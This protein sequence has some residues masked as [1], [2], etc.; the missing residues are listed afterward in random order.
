MS[1][2][3]SNQGLQSLSIHKKYVGFREEKGAVSVRG[4]NQGL[5]SLSIHKKYVRFREEK[6]AVGKRRP[7]PNLNLNLILTS[8]G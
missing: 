5:Q 4:S 7:L 3:G 1:V 8:V 6:G 2:R